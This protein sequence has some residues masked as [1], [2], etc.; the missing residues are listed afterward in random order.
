MDQW[1]VALVVVGGAVLLLGLVDALQSRDQR[2]KVPHEPAEQQC[3]DA[4][5][6]SSIP[7]LKLV[8]I[9]VYALVMTADWLQGPFVYSLYH[10]EYDYSIQLV[11]AL[12]VCGFLSAGCSAP[13]IGD[14]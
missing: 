2:K 12:F 10:D 13:F 4:D 8:Y 1:T 5:S 3:N 14:L 6:Q 11:A 7:R 9:S